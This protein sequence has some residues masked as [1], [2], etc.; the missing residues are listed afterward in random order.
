MRNEAG[1]RG[2][3]AGERPSP[4]WRRARNT[5]VSD[6][7]QQGLKG[8]P[9]CGVV[10]RA[11]G[12]AEGVDRVENQE[13]GGRSRRS[14]I[15]A[16]P[17]GSRGSAGRATRDPSRET[18]TAPPGGGRP[19]RSAGG[20]PGCRVCRQ[21]GVDEEDSGRGRNLIAEEWLAGGDGAGEPQ[22]ERRLADSSSPTDHGRAS[23]GDQAL[24]EPAAGRRLAVLA[25]LPQ[26]LAP[27]WP[28]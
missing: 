7:R 6:R 22:D 10:A 14:S 26:S 19:W 23:L 17:S 3:R 21:L 11:G 2:P 28:I 24:G 18:S 8:V 13:L 4:R 27:K 9:G 15:T 16:C 20:A 1:R 25:R 5:A 12:R